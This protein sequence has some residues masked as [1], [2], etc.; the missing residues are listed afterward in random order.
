MMTMMMMMMMTSNVAE[1]TQCTGSAYEVRPC[2][3]STDRQCLR[4]C[5][6]RAFTCTFFAHLLHRQSAPKKTNI[7]YTLSTPSVDF[8]SFYTEQKRGL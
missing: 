4:E 6:S 5:T 7:S 8:L 2:T 1:C 3:A